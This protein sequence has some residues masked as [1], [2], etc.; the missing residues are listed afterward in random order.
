MAGVGRARAAVSIVNA[1]PT[2]VGAAVGL[3][4]VARATATVTADR[5]PDERLEIAPSRAGTP[6][7]RSAVAA[8]IG[9]YAPA[10]AGARRVVVR[11]TIPV[12]RGLKSSSAVSSAVASAVARAAGASPQPEE[13]ARLSAEVG[14]TTGTS[15]TGAFDDALAG[16][17]AGGVV[18]DNR[19]D[20]LLRVLP[21]ERDL[22]AALWIPARRHPPSP[23]TR[24]RFARSP[25]LARRAA[26]AALD[27]D[28]RAAMAANTELVE[29]AMGYRYARA[30]ESVLRAGA[31]AAGVSGL[32]PTLVALSPR[33]RARRVL[34]AL[35]KGGG[36]RRTVSLFLEPR[37]PAGGGV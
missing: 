23:S 32:G 5:R 36:A 18:T 6:L 29:R 30:R 28:W 15:A 11:S 3:E 13:I 26:D 37:R 7:V 27:G 9:R 17:R 8:A 16:L 22:V 35:P 19:R 10:E 31:V 1:L 4:W 20:A 25:A 14:R 24:R 21:L 12:A 34:A 33:A 2:G